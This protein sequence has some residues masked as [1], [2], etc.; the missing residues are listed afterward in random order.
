[1]RANSDLT[2]CQNG[3]LHIMHE[4]VIAEFF[5]SEIRKYR[6]RQV[7]Y[8]NAIKCYLKVVYILKSTYVN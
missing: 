3:A 8:L 5:E 1:M 2:Y 7:S 4:L 6:M